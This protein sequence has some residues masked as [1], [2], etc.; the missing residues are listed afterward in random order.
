MPACLHKPYGDKASQLTQNMT[1]QHTEVAAAAEYEHYL[2]TVA[3]D[4]HKYGLH[5]PCESVLH[6]LSW[7]CLRVGR[8]HHRTCY[9]MQRAAFLAS[10]VCL[11]LAAAQGSSCSNKMIMAH[12]AQK[13]LIAL[14][15]CS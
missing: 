10:M 7:N 14:G 4:H 15:H 2:R 5:G 3:F 6:S 9:K 11:E 12:L 1:N 13:L 8:A